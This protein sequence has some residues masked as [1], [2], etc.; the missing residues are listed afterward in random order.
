MFFEMHELYD[1]KVVVNGVSLESVFDVLDSLNWE[2]LCEKPILA[3]YHGDF[4]NENILISKSGKPILLD[5]RQNFGSEGLEFGDIYYDFAKFLHGLIVSHKIIN[6]NQF[7]FEFG[8][9]IFDILIDIN[10]PMR[11]IESEKIFYDWL[12]FNSF[13]IKK[14]KILCALIYLNISPLHEHH[15]SLFL[16]NFGRYLLNQW[17]TEDCTN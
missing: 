2:W 9:D 3:R 5:W 13:D 6:S 8:T 10:R 17:N 4:H 15:Y 7:S 1:S 14:V 16:F 12:K 11:L